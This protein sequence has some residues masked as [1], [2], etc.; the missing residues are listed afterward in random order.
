MCARVIMTGAGRLPLVTP[1]THTCTE[2][3][4]DTMVRFDREDGE[5]ERGMEGGGRM[6]AIVGYDPI[7][8]S[9]RLDGVK[10]S[11]KSDGNETEDKVLFAAFK[12]ATVP[13]K[14]AVRLKMVL[15]SKF[16]LDTSLPRLM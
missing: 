1:S 13:E 9:I 11:A 6:Y 16:V 5:E 2:S 7:T 10:F 8:K 12:Y 15:I 14:A 4:A 3:T